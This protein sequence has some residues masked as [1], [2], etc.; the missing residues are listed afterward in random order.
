MKRYG[1]IWNFLLQVFDLYN[2]KSL[3][4]VSYNAEA[5]GNAFGGCR[6]GRPESSVGRPEPWSCRRRKDPDR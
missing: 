5:C 2:R 4:V 3:A 6:A 1:T